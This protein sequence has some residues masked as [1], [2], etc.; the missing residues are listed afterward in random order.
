MMSKN[1]FQHD[2]H[3]VL[4]HVHLRSVTL[5]ADASGSASLL[6]VRRAAR[7]GRTAMASTRAASNSVLRGEAGRRSKTPTDDGNGVHV[8]ESRNAQADE[9]PGEHVDT[10]CAETDYLGGAD[11]VWQEREGR[12]DECAIGG[13]I[14]EHEAIPEKLSIHRSQRKCGLQPREDERRTTTGECAKECHGA[15]SGMNARRD[16]DERRATTG[17]GAKE[18]HGVQSGMNARR[19]EDERRAATGEGAKGHHGAQSG[20]NMRRN[21]KERRAATSTG[22]KGC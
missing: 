19:D 2:D 17:E 7:D 13:T 22:A 6:H 3:A 5:H 16:E 21:G 18:H 14:S 15:Q 8:E 20:M 12:D 10:E 1:T 4:M 11:G 9:D